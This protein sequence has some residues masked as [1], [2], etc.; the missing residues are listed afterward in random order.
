MIFIN[1]SFVHPT[2]SKLFSKLSY[3][4]LQLIENRQPFDGNPLYA[5]LHEPLYCQGRA[6]NWSATRI[7]QKYEQ[8]SWSQ[9]R[10]QGDSAP[11]FFTGEMVFRSMFDDYANLRPWKGAAEIL[12]KDDSW[13]TLYDLEQLWKNKLKVSAVTY[14]N[15]MY[16]DFDFAQETAS[17]IKN[18]EQYITNQLVHD[19]LNEDS[20]DVINTLCKLSKREFN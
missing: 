12:A 16:V 20:Q 17:K 1:L 3:K 4:T 13:S 8:F 6:A 10:I 2:I 11:L 15:D 14:F 18:T 7:L 5:I 9:V 19:G